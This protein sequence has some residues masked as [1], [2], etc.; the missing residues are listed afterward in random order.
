ML[1]FDPIIPSEIAA[2]YYG[3][4][5]YHKY[6]ENGWVESEKHPKNRDVAPKLYAKEFAN[7]K[8][9]EKS[10]QVLL[11]NIYD[12]TNKKVRVFTCENACVSQIKGI[13]RFIVW[14]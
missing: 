1:F 13:R 2:R 8:F 5:Y 7:N 9:S 11:E 4:G 3:Y 10:F 6:Y 14:F 12:L